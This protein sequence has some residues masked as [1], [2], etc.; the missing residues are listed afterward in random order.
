[1]EASAIARTRNNCGLGQRGDAAGREMV[2]DLF[3]RDS[4]E[5]LLQGV[6]NENMLAPTKLGK[7][8]DKVGLGVDIRILVWDPLRLIWL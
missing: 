6:R 1:M 4:P 2:R 8:S 5:S 3:L 7:A